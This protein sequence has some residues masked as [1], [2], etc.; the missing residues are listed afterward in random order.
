MNYDD[1]DWNCEIKEILSHWFEIEREIGKRNKRE[2][3][4]R[5]ELLGVAS[6][7]VDKC[8]YTWDRA[9]V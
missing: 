2:I 5:L 9:C 8:M 4:C 3:R 7:L 1:L 6:A